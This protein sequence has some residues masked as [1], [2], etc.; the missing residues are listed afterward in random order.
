MHGLV[1]NVGNILQNTILF[2]F[3][4]HSNNK[5]FPFLVSKHQNNHSDVNSVQTKRHLMLLQIA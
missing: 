1:E 2:F 4:N 5:R 3:L